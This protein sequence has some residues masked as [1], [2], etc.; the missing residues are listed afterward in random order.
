M[1]QLC[2]HSCCQFVRIV[3]KLNT[4]RDEISV[5][6]VTREEVVV[7]MDDRCVCWVS[8]MGCRVQGADC[9]GAGCGVQ[10]AGCRVKGVGCRV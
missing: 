10:V 2:S 8:G 1:N 6:Q 9:G 7:E 4:H 3:F 5:W